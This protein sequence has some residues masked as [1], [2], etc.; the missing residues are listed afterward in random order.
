M[1][2]PDDAP[3]E[4][5][6]DEA[7]ARPVTPS[8][9]AAVMA[10]LGPWLPDVSDVPPA[11]L[12]VS[13]GGDSLALA[14]LASRWRRGLQAF[15]VDHG[16]RPD[17][18]QEAVEAAERLEAMGINTRILTLH[19]LRAGPGVA[20]RA[21]DA[22]YAALFA[23]CRESGCVD[24]LLGHQADDQI[25][26]I[27]MRRARGE[28]FGLSGM[29][30]IT[31]TP[32]VRVVRPLLGVSR[33]ALRETLRHAGVPWVDDPSND[34]L[35]AE[36]VR[37][38]RTL[39]EG[40]ETLK[41]ELFALGRISGIVR[42][43]HE[44]ACATELASTASLSAGG[45]ATLGHDLPGDA[46]L[47]ALI[48]CVG[49]GAYPPPADAVSALRRRGRAGTLA[50][51]RLFR[52]R[53]VAAGG[54]SW[55]MARERAAMQGRIEARDGVVWD[56]RF[57]LHCDAD[58]VGLRVGAAGMGIDRRAR[59]GVAAAL[60][61]TLPALWRGEQRVCVP[62]LGICEEEALV[63]AEFSFAPNV[64]AAPGGVWGLS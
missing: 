15:V 54:Q 56:R 63:G 48:R 6:F 29:A 49:A 47:A 62:Y 26:T 53:T 32:D 31:E 55:V 17:S 35:R 37:V 61:E 41:A 21:R 13:G 51:A 25:E 10:R 38:R 28:G 52:A 5:P 42:A 27:A 14:W 22:R 11:A 20:D 43:A 2:P 58:M 39:L 57:V 9:F 64:A 30:W 36:R 4:H 16:L 46:A 60:C 7:G 40:G 19:T 12:A 23:A 33:A 45:W 3:A 8:Y 24:L 59:G 34:D 1:T 50:G 18:A 44:N